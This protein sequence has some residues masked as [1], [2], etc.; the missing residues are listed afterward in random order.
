MP[1]CFAPLLA[2]ASTGLKP[3]DYVIM[4]AYVAGLLGIGVYLARRQESTEDF[5]VGGRSMPWWA[6]GL[7]ML[8]TL[9]STLTYLGSPGELIQHGIGQSTSLLALPFAFLVIG[10][11]WVPFFMRLGLTSA[12]E[13][14]ERRF[15]LPTRML[16]VGLYLFLRFVWMGAI[17]FTASRALA[18]LTEDTGPAFLAKAS[19]GALEFDHDSWLLAVLIT[20]GVV[21]TLY[22]ALGGIRAVIWTDVLQFTFL[23]SGA[24]VTLILVAAKTGTGP[25]DW[26]RTAT[27]GG[28]EGH[29]LPPLASW[30]MSTRVTL[31]WT[32]LGG[33]MWHI[34]THASDQVALQRYFTTR[35]ASAARRTAAV[36]YLA[37]FTMAVLL[38]MV[39]MALLTYFSDT[40][41]VTEILPGI[42]DPR[43]PRVADRIFPHF[44]AHGLPVGISGLV[45]AAVFAVAQSSIDS[46]IN[47]TATVIT[48][49]L[50]ARFK[51][52]AM[53]DRVELRLAQGL[54][55]VIGAVVTATG[56]AL[57]MLPERYNILDVTLKTFNLA[58]G[59]L[60]A[61]FMA[62]M[63]MP[64]VGSRA[65]LAAGMI[66]TLCAVYFAFGDMLN[67][68]RGLTPF[69]VIPLSWLVTFT[70]AA[71]LGGLM[72]RPAPEQLR[73]LT[74]RDV[75]LGDNGVRE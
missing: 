39:G 29:T 32:V 68:E 46:G 15:D 26:W 7:S 52:S 16:A 59:P 23:F 6:V 22:T 61:I 11:L 5:F 28:G 18:Q 70:L 3:I 20:T 14:V 37:D 60:G 53:T 17:L 50:V 62:G 42:T 34:C 69:L 33:F 56:L 58:L 64:H 31:L 40:R 10:F 49:D 54:T 1:T 27:A 44:I 65:V 38:A 13:Y 25:V 36:N 30:D 72:R 4:L 74:W 51:R 48:V 21:S 41:Y 12:Y 71:F 35:S 55:L 47:S 43:D 67:E 19:G 24:V 57:T 66:G 9:M 73:G 63:L 75:V 45:V 8:A 2:S